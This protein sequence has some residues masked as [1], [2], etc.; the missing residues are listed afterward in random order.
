[1]KKI[2]TVFILL[3]IAV[4]TYIAYNFIQYRTKNAVSDAAFIKTDSLLTLGFKVGGKVLYMAK[5]EGE[6]VKEGELLAK[7]DERDFKTAA[8]R[9]KKEIEAI[10]Y[11]V[12]RLKVEK[13][14]LKNSL[15]T[16]RGIKG[17]D[18]EMLLAKIE[19]L[20]REIEA[21]E[22]KYEKVS[23]DERRYKALFKSKL[24]PKSRYEDIKSQKSYLYK[25]LL[26]QKA[27]LKALETEVKKA[28]LA[29]KLV[30]IDQKRIKE[31][32]LKIASLQKRSQSLQKRY[33]EI[34]NK[35]SYCY[36][37]SP[38]TG[39][40]AK[41]FVNVERVV[42][43]GEPVYSVVN[44]KDLH[45]E[46]LL[47]EK[48]L[49]GVK[50][51]NSVKITVDAYPDREYK[52]VVEKILPASAATFALV[53]RDISSGE[54]TKLDQRFPVRITLLNPTDDL[55]VGMGASVAIRRD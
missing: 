54:F 1:M 39:S 15:E 20:K 55:R 2:G 38:I 49:K 19:A 50:P 45:V 40:V 51:G 23:K 25:S 42:S 32:G 9:V 8:A 29:I 44:P 30:D 24:I 37:Y 52:G 47:S 12:K 7:L 11:E 48:K 35:I 31:L 26:A 27:R 41:K 34:K 4:F 36:L 22:A 13:E 46:V 28:L 6:S 43:E 18:K 5:K 16:N 17:A 21:M 33:E 10:N 3:L 53:P 14:R